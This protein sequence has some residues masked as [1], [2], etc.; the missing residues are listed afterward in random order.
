MS[1]RSTAAA[2]CCVKRCARAGYRDVDCQRRGSPSPGTTDRPISPPSA[3][4]GSE[5]SMSSAATL[6]R[7]LLHGRLLASPTDGSA[8]STASSIPLRDGRSSPTSRFALCW[9]PSAWRPLRRRGSACRTC[10][11]PRP[12]AFR[13]RLGA[14]A[15]ERDNAA[16]ISAAQAVM[17]PKSSQPRYA[18]GSCRRGGRRLRWRC[19]GTRAPAM[20]D[21]TPPDQHVGSGR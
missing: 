15:R 11:G 19:R 20:A 12:D 14:M 1:L 9:V 5:A 7:K 10:G 8:S 4:A 18:V 17:T 21:G 6:I 16:E 3:A 13:A 2:A